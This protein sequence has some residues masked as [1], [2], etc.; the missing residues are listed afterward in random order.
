MNIA[1]WAP[2]LTLVVG[3]NIVLLSAVIV[4]LSPVRSCTPQDLFK[5]IDFC[6][7]RSSVQLEEEGTDEWG[8][9]LHETVLRGREESLSHI[10]DVCLHSSR[11]EHLRTRLIRIDNLYISAR[12][13]C[14]VRSLLCLKGLPSAR[15]S[16]V[17]VEARGAGNSSHLVGDVGI[18]RG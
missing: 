10:T 5:R 8:P 12:S 4:G 13:F 16:S 9:V 1:E 11:L 18:G 2:S 17:G 15:A 6:S 3:S 7:V 14:H